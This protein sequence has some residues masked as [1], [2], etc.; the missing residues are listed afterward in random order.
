MKFE[1]KNRFSGT[2][3]FSIET[4]TWKLAVEA[5]V[6]ASANLRSADLSYADLSSANL[7]SA[8]LRSANL[9]YADLSSANL[10]SADLRSADLGSAD[11]SSADLSS[12]DL[13]YA[14]L[15]SA[16]LSSADL[17]YA[18]LRYANLSS[19]DLSSANLG[20]ADLRSADLSSANLR[21]ADLSSADLRSAKGIN[22]YRS[23]PLLMLL[24]QP[25][26]IRAY[27]LV[28]ENFEGPFNGGIKY[29]GKKKIK[30]DDANTSDTEQCAAGINLA[31]LDWCMAGWR[32]GYHI[33]VA[34][35][36]A[37]DI[38]AIPIATDGKFRVRQCV[39]VGEKDL[40][41]IGLVTEPKTEKEAKS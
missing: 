18:N 31:T 22:K 27:K 36:E 26:K 7:S 16:D 24:D 4:E 32:P 14:D 38:A 33:L 34:E 28:N 15:R 10:G 41:E 25:G 5:A 13:R 39:I 40:K 30:V 9:S 1:I 8:D 35:F 6:K 21:S 20:S 37:K 17:C 12:A 11:L 29:I 3:L 23:T 19:A 2:L